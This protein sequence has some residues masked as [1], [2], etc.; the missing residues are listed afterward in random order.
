MDATR[1]VLE[2]RLDLERIDLL[3]DDELF[4]ALTDVFGV[5]TKVANCVALFGYHRIGRAPIDTW[6]NK[7]IDEQYN[8]INPFP[9]Y[10]E[11]AGV[12]QQ[13]MFYSAQHLK[14]L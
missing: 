2:G 8:G 14:S 5:G 3:S 12:L 7:V 6:I 9:N 13:Y 4:L 11:S 1:R 10:P